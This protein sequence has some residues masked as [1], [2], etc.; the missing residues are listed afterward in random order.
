LLVHARPLAPYQA[1]CGEGYRYLYSLR[2]GDIQ[3][4]KLRTQPKPCDLHRQDH[5][6]KAHASAGVVL[7]NWRG[8]ARGR[9]YALAP[10][11]TAVRRYWHVSAR[12]KPPHVP[13]QH[14]SSSVHT[15]S[16]RKQHLPVVNRHNP[17]LSV[18]GAQLLGSSAFPGRLLHCES[19][20]QG[21]PGAQHA[22]HCPS[23]QHVSPVGQPTWPF[24]QQTLLG[25]QVA[26]Q[27]F[28]PSGQHAVPQKRSFGQ[29]EGSWPLGSR[30]V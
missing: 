7:K 25:T 16:N 23:G 13:E 27:H 17:P 28:S 1:Y 14:C 8:H 11:R 12:P 24:V 21:L 4:S 26:P 5:R 9:S 3:G 6:C 2:V 30:H 10:A 18:R 22:W 19:S 20:V 15:V 29:H